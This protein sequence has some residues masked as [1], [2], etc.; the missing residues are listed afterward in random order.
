MYQSVISNS[1]C[2]N[3]NYRIYADSEYIENN[4]SYTLSADVSCSNWIDLNVM[5]LTCPVGFNFKQRPQM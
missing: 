2:Q 1:S 3:V 4:M 5:I